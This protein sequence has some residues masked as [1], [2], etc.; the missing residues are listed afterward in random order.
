MPDWPGVG[1]SGYIP[2]DQLT[3]NLLIN[4][5]FKFTY[6]EQRFTMIDPN[7]TGQYDKNRELYK[8]Y[9]ASEKNIFISPEIAAKARVTR[10][11]GAKFLSHC[12]Q[13]L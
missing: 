2:L 5:P 13:N 6:Y 7:N 11:W 1:R 8:K 9:T 4:L 12:A 10:S 3:G